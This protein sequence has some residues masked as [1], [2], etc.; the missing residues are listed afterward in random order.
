[1]TCFELFFKVPFLENDPRSSGTQHQPFPRGNSKGYAFNYTTILTIRPT[2][3]Q[4]LHTKPLCPSEVFRAI[5]QRHINFF[6]HYQ[7]STGPHCKPNF[8]PSFPMMVAY[9]ILH[10]S[11]HMSDLSHARLLEHRP[12]EVADWNPHLCQAPEFCAINA[13]RVV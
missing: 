2:L 10:I 12:V 7:E 6:H 13:I 5:R 9:V 1:M 8:G 3:V 11:S 4:T